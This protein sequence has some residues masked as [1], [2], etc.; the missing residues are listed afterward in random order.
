MICAGC[1]ASI[2]DHVKF[3]SKCGTK[4][5]AVTAQAPPMKRCSNGG[6]NPL[7][8]KFCK[9][10]GY[11]LQQAEQAPSMG[12]KVKSGDTCLFLHFSQNKAVN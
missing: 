5:D 4:T 1:R 9:A 12:V 6:D 2:P 11:P 3:C 7:S 10:D 8:A